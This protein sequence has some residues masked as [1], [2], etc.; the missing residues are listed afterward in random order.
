MNSINT[1]ARF[2]GLFWALTFL[3]GSFAMYA[4][5]TVVVSGD[6]AA[7]AANILALESFYRAGVVSNLVATVSYLA[8]TV[9][10]Y[11]LLKPVNRTVSLLAA[12]F[13]LAGCA[14]SALGFVFQL[15]PL[16]A[17]R[18]AANITVFTVE[19][20][21]VLARISL[22]L[23]EQASQ[24]T[25][26]FF[27]L[28]CLLVGGLIL[29]SSFMHRA[30]GVLMA[31]GGLGWLTFALANLLSPTLARSLTPYILLPGMIG[32]ASLIVSLLVK[33]VN[34]PRWLEQASA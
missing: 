11:Y 2:A 28:H 20:L 12:F 15:G 5:G 24:I 16:V 29:G 23:S 9:L 22:R 7:T 30:V 19:Q 25:F 3:T 26:L 18:S 33:G 8:A 13:S 27:G 14:L 32:E 1:T 4:Y 21:E 6:A 10:V 17:L 31:C 34:V